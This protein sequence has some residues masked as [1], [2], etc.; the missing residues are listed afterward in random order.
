M[1][2]LITFHTCTMPKNITSL[3]KEVKGSRVVD[4]KEK[5]KNKKRKEV[6][7]GKPEKKA[8]KENPR[9]PR[10]YS[11][12]YCDATI[13]GWVVCRHHIFAKHGVVSTLSE[14]LNNTLP[15]AKV[16]TSLEEVGGIGEGDN[17]TGS[18]EEAG[19][20]EDEEESD[21]E[22]EDDDVGWLANAKGFWRSHLA[23]VKEGTRQVTTEEIFN[24]SSKRK[25]RPELMTKKEYV[26]LVITA[27]KSDDSFEFHS[28]SQSFSL[29]SG[30]DKAVAV[31]Q[32]A[33]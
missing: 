31:E 8:K 25:F 12:P 26:R 14:L 10:E 29:V 24:K 30:E 19:V 28:A 33:D 16:T 9:T 22:D 11:C 23:A 4:F 6:Q 32:E 20:S 7:Q 3:R 21:E 1:E 18:E 5:Y 2:P 27:M 15:P 17:D 13:T